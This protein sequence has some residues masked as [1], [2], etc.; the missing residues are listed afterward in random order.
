[1][2]PPDFFIACYRFHLCV[3][4]PIS[5]PTYKGST[6]HGGFSHGLARIG[7]RFRDYFFAEAASKKKKGPEPPKPFTLIPPLEEQTIYVI[8]EMMTC[9]L[10]LF[11][12]AIDQF[13]IAFAAIET[14]GRDLG[15]GVDSGRFRILR[16][17]QITLDGAVPIFEADRWQPF[18]PGIGAQEL[19]E[20]HMAEA[21][22]V[23]LT[24]HTR[25]RLKNDNMLVRE[26]PPFSIFFDR[27]VGRVNSLGAFYGSGMLMPPP[28]KRAMI[29][30]AEKVRLDQERTTAGWSEWT[31]PPKAGKDEMSFGG[32]LGEIGYVGGLSP[33]IPWL[34]LGQWTG[35]GGK[36]SFGLGLYHLDIEGGEDG[37]MS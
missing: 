36:T 24:L 32:L 31:R 29:D 21:R 1:M 12:P 11:G 22:D 18:T 33:F 10:I 5:L 34:A 26:P 2:P 3:T 16:V 27:L 25:L 15:L 6:F 37:S 19:L 14:L 8:G 30:L 20:S 13:M 28:Q 4:R 7:P 9:G 23:H 17:E 35:V